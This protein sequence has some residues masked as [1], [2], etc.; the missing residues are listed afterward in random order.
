MTALL[1][2]VNRKRGGPKWPLIAHT[3]IMFSLATVNTGLSLNGQSLSYIDNRSFP[4]IRG[5]LSPGPL[6]WQNLIY[7]D[8]LETVPSI[9]FQLSQWLAD[10][11]LMYRCYIIYAKN[12]RVIAFPCAIYLAS[13]ATGIVLIYIISRPNSLFLEHRAIQNFGTAYYSTSL[14]LN[15]ILTLMIVFR[16]V[17]HNRKL[18]SAMG[19][20]AVTNG[21]YGAIITMLIESFA[22][23]AVTFLLFIGSWG[24]DSNLQYLFSAILAQVQ[25]IAPFLVVLRV[26]NQTSFTNDAV[27]PGNVGSLHFRSEE[28]STGYDGTFTDGNPTSSMVIDRETPDQLNSE[29]ESVI[30]HV[31]SRQG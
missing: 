29:A 22:L 4:G 8:P 18:R 27:V 13:L 25:V 2:P 3:V 1:N 19:A 7:S 16:L 5:V 12:Y 23:Y 21:L 6:A 20:R 30:E 17:R 9:T 31:P 26:A 28:T 11:L 15:V 10:G 14:S 24:A